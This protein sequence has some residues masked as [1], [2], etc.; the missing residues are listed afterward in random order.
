MMIVHHTDCGALQYTDEGVEEVLRTRAPES[1]EIK[2]MKFGA[3]TDVPQSV[4]DDLTVL[5][6]SPLVREELKENASGYVFDVKT[7]LLTPV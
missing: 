6:A 3:I 7:G 2:D 5:K 1:S 4:K